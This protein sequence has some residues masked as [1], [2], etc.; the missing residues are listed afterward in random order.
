MWEK[1]LRE[2]CK[3]VINVLAPHFEFPGFLQFD[4]NGLVSMRFLVL[5]VSSFFSQLVKCMKM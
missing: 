2:I 5:R 3:C 4:F 1:I